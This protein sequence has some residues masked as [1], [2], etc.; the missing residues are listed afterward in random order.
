VTSLSNWKRGIPQ[1]IGFPATPDA[2]GGTTRSVVVND[3]GWITRFTD[4]NGFSSHY[5]HDP[6]GRVTLVQYPEGDSTNWNATT[7]AFERMG[8]D[9]WGIP[10]GH[11]RQTVSTGNGRK[12]TYFDGLWRPLLV[13]EFDAADQAG[14]QR[15]QRYAYDHAGRTTFASYP[16][17][18]AAT[19]TGTWT[20]YDALGRVTSSAQDS[21]YGVLTATTAYMPGLFTLVTSPKGVRTYSRYMAWDQPTYDYPIVIDQGSGSPEQA[22]V[23]I[24]RDVFGKPTS[25][26]KRDAS[27]TQTLTRQYV[28][29]LHQQLCKTIEP[30]TGATILAYDDAGNLAWSRAGSPLTAVDNCN[31]ADVPAVERTTRH[32]DAR[33]RIPS[34][35]FPDNRGNTNYWYAPDGQIAQMVVDNG[36]ARVATTVYT[37]NR[38]RMVTGEAMGV[39]GVAWGIGYGFDANGHLASQTHSA[40]GLQ[41]DYAPNGLGQA[42]AAGTYASNARYFP[43]GALKQFTYGNGIVHSMT[44]NVR[45]LPDRS[46]DALG[47]VAAYDES[48]D[49]DAHGNVAA[50]SD[51][52]PGG[53]GDRTMAYDALDR[54]TATVSPMF[55]SATYAY[56]ALD[57]LRAV[58]VTAGAHTRAHTYHYD[59]AN[60]LSAVSNAAG[61][62]VAS[63]AYDAQGNLASKGGQAYVFDYGNRLRD[64]PGVEQYRYDGHGRRVQAI[65]GGA[66]LYSIYG[67]DGVLRYQRNEHTGMMDEYVYLAGRQVARLESPLPL[68]APGLAVPGYSET[69]SYAVGWSTVP[70]ST[71]YQLEEQRP[72]A[73]W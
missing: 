22:S 2:P 71:T 57:N 67:H 51:G 59:A 68:A 19:S 43:N 32:Y 25:I 52:L 10:A 45:G 13:H 41:L 64:V 55:G 40:T 58:Q 42:T 30:E 4:E 16:S 46:R 12:L 53:R 70:H 18:Q 48:F 72:G 69:G 44:Q 56:D 27:G 6:M 54:L 65:R 66:S 35:V 29:N 15:F 36:G 31:T 73:D 37:H 24:M 38:R 47:G 23:D 14:T 39:G 28:Y 9:A 21:E 34:L 50:I 7:R 33:N 49:Y 62:S 20:E 8:V 5:A 17:D 60:R 11:W 63:L 3:S 1:S 61:A 26:R